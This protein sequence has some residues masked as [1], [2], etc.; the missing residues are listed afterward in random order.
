MSQ[1]SAHRRPRA[2]PGHG[3]ESGE[4]RRYRLQGALHVT[5]CMAG[6]LRHLNGPA[7][8]APWDKFERSCPDSGFKF[9]YDDTSEVS[10]Y[11]VHTGSSPDVPCR[12][13]VCTVHKPPGRRALSIAPVWTALAPRS[14]ARQAC[15]A[16][17]LARAPSSPGCGSHAGQ[18][19]LYRDLSRFLRGGAV[20][21]QLP[22]RQYHSSGGRAMSA[23]PRVRG[24]APA[25]PP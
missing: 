16:V 21:T 22:P 10:W 20:T 13:P 3:S 15:A 24:S 7:A 6:T 11:L 19:C 23:V 18:C 5:G 1:A 17:Q 9:K 14:T 12:V 8:T 25:T 4:S 2:F